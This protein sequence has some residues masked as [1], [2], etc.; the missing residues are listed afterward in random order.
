MYL[1]S[2]EK[3]DVGLEQPI[4]NWAKLGSAARES[5]EEGQPGCLG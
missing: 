1:F 2:F 5:L 3:L 4:A